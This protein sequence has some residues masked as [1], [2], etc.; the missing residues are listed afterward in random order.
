MLKKSIITISLFLTLACG[1]APEVV[2][3]DIQDLSVPDLNYLEIAPEPEDE[4][5]P[6]FPETPAHTPS[7]EEPEEP[8]V[9]EEQPAEEEDQPVE[10]EQEE[11]VPAEEEQEEQEE[12]PPVE[13]EEPAEEEQSTEE[14]V[15]EEEQST[16]EE[17]IEEEPVEE[18]VTEEEQIS[19]SGECEL[20]GDIY[21]FQ[22][23]CIYPLACLS[24]H[25]DNFEV[26][27]ETGF[28]G[29]MCF[30][31]SNCPEDTQCVMN[32]VTPGVGYC[33]R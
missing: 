6:N 21:T 13:Q 28:C 29:K 3:D 16:E 17:V 2:H 25:V 14:E 26:V 12:E 24:R 18:E 23:I 22:S 9:E 32:G 1:Q 15:I 10:E 20:G 5:C 19:F 4:G 11:E 33:E 27:P 8:P 7:Q 31:D 30:G